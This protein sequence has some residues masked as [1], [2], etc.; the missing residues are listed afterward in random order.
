MPTIVWD[1]RADDTM[2]DSHFDIE[3]PTESGF[4]TPS[5]EEK[6]PGDAGGDDYA[7][8][9]PSTTPDLPTASELLAH[10]ADVANA[11]EAEKSDLLKAI[12]PNLIPQV[13]DA[14]AD[15]GIKNKSVE[16]VCHIP[17]TRIPVLRYR[18]LGKAKKPKSSRHRG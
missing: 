16:F 14:S 4:A 12:P 3:P 15:A 6:N 11:A 13:A 5:V 7:S 9:I 1:G 17:G 18:K 2:R 10:T 8:G